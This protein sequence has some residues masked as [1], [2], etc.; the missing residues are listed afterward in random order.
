VIRKHQ[1]G[2]PRKEIAQYLLM[3]VIKSDRQGA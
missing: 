3:E 2:L 1:N